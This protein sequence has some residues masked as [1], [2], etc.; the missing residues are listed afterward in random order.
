MKMRKVA[1]IVLALMFCASVFSQGFADS[2]K[3][4]TTKTENVKPSVQMD[5]NARQKTKNNILTMS[6]AWKQTS[7]E[8]KALYHQGFNL[9]KMQVD[10]ALKKQKPEDKPLA[11]IT[12][13]DDTI[14]SPVNYW[15]YLIENGI[16]FFDDAVWDQWVP[17]NKFIPT[18]GALEFL[19]YCKKNKVEVFYVTSRN[20]GEK[21]YEYASG[22]LKAVNFPYVDKEHLIVLMET[23]NKENQKTPC[24]L[25]NEGQGVFHTNELMNRKGGC[26]FRS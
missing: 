15:G 21:T 10:E 5:Q 8:Y 12:D 11:I 9:A 25:K 4:E 23:S 24:S 20:Q 26:I 19:N 22:N 18:A 17:Q 14:L 6:V 16:D 7:A 3:V 2:K 13:V 1:S